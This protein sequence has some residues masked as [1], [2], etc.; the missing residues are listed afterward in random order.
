MIASAIRIPWGE[1]VFYGSHY[2]VVKEHRR[3]GYGT[4]LRDQ[5]A[6]EYVGD[7][8]LCVDAENGVANKNEAK[9]G[10]V[11]AGFNTGRFQGVAKESVDGVLQYTSGRM[12]KVSVIAC[13]DV[14]MRLL[15]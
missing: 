8:I 5:V 12:V 7:N 3:L 6:R 15:S 10:Y 14:C 13:R 9:F 4:R 11:K 2:Y 1:N